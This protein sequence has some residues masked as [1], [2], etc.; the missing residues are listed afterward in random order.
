MT[1]SA[2]ADH[3]ASDR[4][5]RRAL[6]GAGVLGAALA[7]AG[8]RSASA[9]ATLPGLSDADK[10]IASF[11]I[12]LEL[13]ARDLYD[14]AIEAGSSG[15]VWTMMREQH[16]A[17]ATRIA[18]LAGISARL[19]NDD[20]FDALESSFATTDP[21]TAALDLENVAAA[22]HIGLLEQIEGTSFAEV[23]AAIGA[24]E[25]R[26]ATVLG[27][28]AGETGDALFINPATPLEA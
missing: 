3:A 4:S 15:D 2:V 1:D 23:V 6:L 10:E 5:S 7:L 25:S 21:L 8:S 24:M 17:Y 13:T 18:G 9:G 26:H 20:V 27:T 22:T 12:A 28:V 19:R 16:E 14:A 11:A